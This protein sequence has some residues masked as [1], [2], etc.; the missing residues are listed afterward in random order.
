MRNLFGLIGLLLFIPLYVLG[1]MWVAT[2]YI[3]GTNILIQ[4]VFYLVAGIIWTWPAI[5][6]IK[7]IK[8]PR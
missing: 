7:W 3:D 4:T 6:V 5:Q 1:V 8:K 2:Q